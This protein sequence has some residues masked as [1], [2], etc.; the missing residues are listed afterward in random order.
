MPDLMKCGHTAQGVNAKTQKPVCVICDCTEIAEGL[1]A[2][3]GRKAKC[4]Y[5]SCHN[6]ADSSY[7]LPFFK[8]DPNIGTDQY[9]CGCMGWD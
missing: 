7:S 2:L 8:H 1:P 5:G 4:I 3:E 9:Y 6:T